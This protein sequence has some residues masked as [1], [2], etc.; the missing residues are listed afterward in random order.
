LIQRYFPKRIDMN[1]STQSEPKQ[2]FVLFD[3]PPASE[4]SLL[5]S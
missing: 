3:L 2:G 1:G 5:D 4:I